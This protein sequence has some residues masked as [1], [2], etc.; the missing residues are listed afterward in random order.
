MR[1]GIKPGTS[2]LPVLR[3]EPFGH[4]WSGVEMEKVLLFEIKKKKKKKLKCNFYRNYETDVNDF[5]YFI[6]FNYL[7]L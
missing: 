6:F 5:Y 4:W 2:C 1:P 7:L 3:T